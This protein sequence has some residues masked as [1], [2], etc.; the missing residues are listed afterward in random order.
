[1]KFKALLS[2]LL[3]VWPAQAKS[4]KTSHFPRSTVPFVGC[5]SDTQ[6]GIKEPPKGA[7]I[8]TSLD[9]NLA[10][11]LAYYTPEDGPG[12]LA[13]RGWYC[14]GN[15]SFGGDIILVRPAPIQDVSA[16]DE[17]NDVA[18]VAEWTMNGNIGEVLIAKVAMR[19]FPALHDAVRPTT[20]LNFFSPEYFPVG[21]FPDDRL[22]YRNDHAVA[23]ETPAGGQGLGSYILSP[24][25]LAP[26]RGAVRISQ[27]GEDLSLDM[28][29]VR[30]PQEFDR[31]APAITTYYENQGKH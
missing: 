25:P 4:E 7:P 23:Y 17:K 28:I 1:M 27:E 10:E 31:L 30:L 11:E 2:S 9:P 29:A 26:T 14:F 3:L 24:S 20:T 6:Y 16:F 22:T 13:P 12:V 8:K 19:V 18:V 15:G 5:K 21:P